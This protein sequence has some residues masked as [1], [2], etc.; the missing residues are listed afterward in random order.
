MNESLKISFS[1]L[2][3]SFS[4]LLFSEIPGDLLFTNRKDI[5]YVLNVNQVS[6]VFQKLKD[7]YDVVVY[8]NKIIS[9]YHTRYFDT[10]DFI[11]YS[12]HQRGKLN[13]HKIRIR[14][15]QD[16]KSFLEVKKKNNKGRTLKDRVGV[17][18]SSFRIEDYESFIFDVTS[19]KLP[20]L[21]E[22][23]NVSYQRLTFFHKSFSE[24]LTFDF[25]YEA[26]FQNQNVKLDQLV[27]IESK[28]TDPNRSTFNRSIKDIR[29]H[30]VS[31]SKYCY[32]I[33]KLRSSAK[34][35]N[36]IPQLRTIKKTIDQYDNSSICI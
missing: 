7:D 35:N 2:E 16:G 23:L 26:F 8:D 9:L 14:T 22:K 5:K 25:S 13:R 11:F 27:L 36:F 24:K 34:I 30:P 15:Y 19:K 17:D 18:L 21:D 31:F 6:T 33:S 28:S 4:R 29:I 12:D 20:P 1:E 3:S 32:G 10:D